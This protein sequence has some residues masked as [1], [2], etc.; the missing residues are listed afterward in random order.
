MVTIIGAETHAHM[1]D[2]RVLV[3]EFASWAMSTFH[4]DETTLPAVF[5]G[6]ERELSDLPGKYAAPDGALLIAY[7]GAE[8]AGCVAGFRSRDGAF[9]VTRLWVRAECRGMGVGD[10][11]VDA[12]LTRASRSG[13]RRAI[14]RSRKEMT[15]AHNVYRRAGFVDVDGNALFSNFRDIEVAMER[16][17][18]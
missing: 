17:L 6:L 14:L 3:R 4:K 5:A 7:N 10:R 8:P 11:L 15:P 12:L 1:Q 9:E 2:F 16:D 18:A 13:Y